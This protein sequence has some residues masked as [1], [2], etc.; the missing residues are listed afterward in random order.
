MVSPFLLCDCDFRAEETSKLT[1]D[2]CIIGFFYIFIY[3][4]FKIE[5]K[6]GTKLAVVLLLRIF[7]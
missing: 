6:S 7:G 3:F 4:F 2:K 5:N 1:K